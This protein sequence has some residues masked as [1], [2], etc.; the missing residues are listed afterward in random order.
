M[1]TLTARLYGAAGVALGMGAATVEVGAVLGLFRPTPAVT[2]VQASLL[3]V[4]ATIL[5]VA[6][7]RLRIAP[8]GTAGADADRGRRQVELDLVLLTALFVPLF[9]ASLAWLFPRRVRASTVDAHAWFEQH[10]RMVGRSGLP[11]VVATEE[12]DAL[13]HDVMSFSEVLR[14]G[15][16]DHKQ[17]ALRKLA[18]RGTPRHLGMLREMLYGDNVELRLCA[19]GELQALSRVHESRLAT[20]QAKVEDTAQ[21]AAED[22][23]RH[24]L[25]T[26][27]AEAHQTYATSGLLDPEMRRYHL[28]RGARLAEEAWLADPRQ[29]RVAAVYARTLS[30]LGDHA[31]AL[32][33]LDHVRDDDRDRPEVCVAEAEIAFRHR[34]FALAHAAAD[35]LLHRRLTL[36]DWLQA[37]VQRRAE[38]AGVGS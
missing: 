8:H 33:A 10:E 27:A 7:A 34:D 32:R 9:G 24:Q 36:P 37:L 31:H 12:D 35:R 19:Y 13:P 11:G 2:A 20:L 30:D 26:E 25:L 16:L 5:C 38:R 14:R 29:W 22:G 28:Q 21:L 6:A 3:H 17:N 15:S 18:Q 23:A 4:T 1:A